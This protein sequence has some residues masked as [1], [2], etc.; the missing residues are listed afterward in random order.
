MSALT[1]P[2]RRL[3]SVLFLITFVFAAAFGQGSKM[4]SPYDRIEAADR[5]NPR[6]RAQW[7]MRGREA[8]RGQ[9]AAILRLGAQQQKLALRVK[10]AEAARALGTRGTNPPQSGWINLGPAPLA[11]WSGQSYGNVT[12]RITAVAVDPTDSTG[13]TVYVGAASGGVWRSTNAVAADPMSVSWAPLTDAQVTLAT[14]AISIKSD[15]SVILVG[16]G[17]PNNALSNYYGLGFLRSTNRGTNWSLV[18]T[19]NNGAYSLAGLGVSKMAWGTTSGL[20]N[21]VV[22]GLEITAEGTYE[23]NYNLLAPPGF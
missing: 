18:S 6:G 16:T 15:A 8:P 17:E 3:A 19:A 10:R 1:R 4:K 9:S 5:D 21:T 12:G 7:M 23:G 13:N 22:A 14:G 2:L 20:T 11:T